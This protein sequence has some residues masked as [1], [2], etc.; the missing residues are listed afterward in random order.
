MTEGAILHSRLHADTKS[1]NSKMLSVQG[2]YQGVRMA[3]FPGMN[4]SRAS[5]QK[6]TCLYTDLSGLC[7]QSGRAT[8]TAASSV[9][10]VQ[11]EINPNFTVEAVARVF[12]VLSPNAILPVF[13]YP[14]L[15]S[16][17]SCIPYIATQKRERLIRH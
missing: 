15:E 17:S 12:M 10:L 5:Q 9:H 6:Q 8:H 2:R 4:C 16:I 13:K 1:V 3:A 14:G 7:K 11:R